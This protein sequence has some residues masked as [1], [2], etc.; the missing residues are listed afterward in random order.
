MVRCMACCLTPLPA[1]AQAGLQRRFN[2]ERLRWVALETWQCLKT[3][4]I[5]SE[6]LSAHASIDLVLT[7]DSVSTVCLNGKEIG[8]TANAHRYAVMLS[9]L[10]RISAACQ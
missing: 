9:A 5:S 4:H 8:Q 7:V 10:L 2:E 6:F 1:H 3:F